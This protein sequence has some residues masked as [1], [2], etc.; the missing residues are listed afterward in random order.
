MNTSLIFI[1]I[2]ILLSMIGLLTYLNVVKKQIFEDLHA[3]T[4]EQLDSINRIQTSLFESIKISNQ[5]NSQSLNQ[6]INHFT[7]TINNLN[8]NQKENIESM[9]HNV[10]KELNMGF[11]KSQQTFQDVI[12]RITLIDA[13][14]QNIIKLSEDVVSLQSLLNDKRSRGA[15]GEVQLNGLIENM[16][17]P[18]HYKFQYTLSNGKRVD[19]MLFFPKPTGSIAVDAKFPLENYQ[20]S[21][22]S[23][24]EQSQKEQA[25]RQFK[26]DIQHHIHDIAQKYI[27]PGETGPGALM[28]IPAESIF[29]YI[30][31]NYPELIQLSQKMHIWLV[32]PTTLMAVLTTARAVIKDDA[33]REQVHIIQSHLQHLSQDFGRFETRLNQLVKHINQAAQDVEKTH[34]SSKKI[35]DKFKKIENVELKPTTK[36]PSI[37]DLN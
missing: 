27:I 6:H 7:Q 25:Q 15:F 35:I 4:K 23:S 13:A 34:I 29:A 22:N 28:F 16:I 36:Q 24:L 17:P 1:L 9:Q 8:K 26:K 19:C 21:I 18:Q 2:F 32:S 30:H 37:D 10:R 33:T 31:A 11:D 3:S 20:A 12:K 14:Q 5:Q